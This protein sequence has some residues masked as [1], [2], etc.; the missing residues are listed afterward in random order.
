MKERTA[1]HVAGHR[2]RCSSCGSVHESV[3]SGICPGCGARVEIVYDLGLEAPKL[4]AADIGI[5]R[6][7]AL[8]PFSAQFIADFEGD[9][10]VGFHI[11]RIVKMRHHAH[12]PLLGSGGEIVYTA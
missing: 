9:G 4:I 11:D 1:E 8:L 5:W 3:E 12:G 6:Y 7:R 2:I 10:L